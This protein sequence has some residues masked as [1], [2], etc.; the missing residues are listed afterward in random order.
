MA[1]RGGSPGVCAGFR[2]QG[3]PARH[4]QREGRLW[5][6][7]WAGGRW[8]I[9]DAQILL[10][11]VCN[12]YLQASNGRWLDWDAVHEE[13]GHGENV[14]DRRAKISMGLLRINRFSSPSRATK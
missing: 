4:E 2:S 11:S 14:A 6:P 7:D 13:P 9:V 5:L 12:N 8:L 1:Q 10:S 3:C